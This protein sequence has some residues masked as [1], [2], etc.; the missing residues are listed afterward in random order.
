MGLFLISKKIGKLSI[1]KSYFKSG[2]YSF[3]T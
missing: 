2:H 1:D 3:K